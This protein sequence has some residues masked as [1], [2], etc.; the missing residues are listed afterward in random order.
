MARPYIN[1]KAIPRTDTTI[2]SDNLRVTCSGR[3]VV[4]PVANTDSN[5]GHSVDPQDAKRQCKS[6]Y[7]I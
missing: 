1:V 3:H 7:S 4:S 5:T 6:D 2:P